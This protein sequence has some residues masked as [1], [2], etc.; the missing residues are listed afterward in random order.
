MD[1]MLR[2]VE[3]QLLQINRLLEN[4][5]AQSLKHVCLLGAYV[6]RRVNLALICEKKETVPAE[7]LTHC[8][9]ESLTYLTQYGVAC[10][11]HQEGSG[12]VGSRDAQTAYDF[13]EDCLEAALPSLSAM[14]VR[15]ECGARFSVRLMLEDA[16]GLPD[17]SAYARQ[18]WLTIDDADGAPCA[19]LS[20][21]RGGDG[22]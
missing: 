20:F 9:R 1:A 18:G 17:E 2:L 13:F 7:E 5:T 19:T 16:A 21:D 15:V 14:M 10:A 4:G 12:S 8:I 11:L 6:K 3:P 22:G